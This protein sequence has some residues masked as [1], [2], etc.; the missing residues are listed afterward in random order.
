MGT[1]IP[2]PDPEYGSDCSLCTPA[3]WPAG[4]TP[5]FFYAYVAG[6]VNCGVSPFNAP[7]GLT[8]KLEQ[9]PASLC[10]WLHL[11][12]VWQLDFIADQISP[13]Q[14]RLRLLD[15]HGFS[16]FIGTGSACPSEF[17]LYSNNQA[18]CILSYAG[19]AG[20]ILIHWSAQVLDLVEWFGLHAGVDLMHEIFTHPDSDIVHKFCDIVQSTNIK[21]KLSI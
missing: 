7:N 10:T 9:N 12:D 14:S 20:T 21:I 4:E 15:K 19:S 16:F 8:F 5:E 17:T 3:R 2:S 11:G 6:I 13:N 1:P 18:S